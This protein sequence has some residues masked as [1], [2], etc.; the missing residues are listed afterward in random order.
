MSTMNGP[1]R[2]C[3]AGLVLSLAASAS[4]AAPPIR[5]A[6]LPMENREVTVKAFLPL[7]EHLQ[8]EL[9]Q[10]VE[11][12]YFDRYD[13]IVEGFIADKLD[14]A[15]FGPLPYLTMRERNP[16]T[17]PLIFFREA[18]GST[19]YRCA[20]VAFVDDR[21]KLSQLKG[22]R[23]G[24][25][26]RLSTCGYL[27][28][29]HILRKHAGLSLDATHYRYIGSHEKV[30]RAVVGGE[31]DVGGVKEEFAVKFATLGVKI[32]ARSDEVPAVGLAGNGHTLDADIRAR[33]R[34]VLLDTPKSVYQ[35]WG[36]TISHGMAPA[37]DA[38]FATLR[39]FGDI[40][41]IPPDP[42]SAGK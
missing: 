11:L 23:V 39:A 8:K 4:Q 7:V 30:I 34:R 24:L 21:V 29:D 37:S 13:D 16:A 22:K 9:G 36:A 12:V 31:F 19:R 20:L 28:T 26:Q 1:I 15:F 32:I 33:I 18:D 40:K 3:A 10:P 27:G 17:D 5:F 41:A 42:A 35:T 38:E 2:A 6:P 14:I 25:T